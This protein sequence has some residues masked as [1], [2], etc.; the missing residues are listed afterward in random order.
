MIKPTK[1]QLV[2]WQR[3]A[4]AYAASQTGDLPKSGELVDERLC[5]LAMSAG[6]DQGLREAKEVCEGRSILR[7]LPAN[8]FEIERSTEARSCAAAIEQLR[9]K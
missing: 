2:E 9:G 8:H 3:Q 5:A 1:E 4:Y 7:Y 6:R